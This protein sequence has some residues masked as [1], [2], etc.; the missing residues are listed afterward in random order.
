VRSLNIPA[1]L[2]RVATREDTFFQQNV[3]E[4]RQLNS[5]VAIV[6][7]VEGKELFLDPGARLCPFGL[8]EWK[9]TSARGIR[10]RAG[11]ATELAETPQPT[12][13]DATTQRVAD[14]KLQRDGTLRG[15]IA[16]VWAG[17]QA[18][19][20]R[21]DGAQTDDAGRKKAAEDELKSL[22]EA[23]A[24][25]KLDSLAS[26]DDSERP[27]KA[28]FNV[29][30]PGY[31]QITGKRVLLPSDLFLSRHLFVTETRKTPVYFEYPYRTFDRVVITLPPDVHLENLPQAQTAKADFAICSVQRT[32]TG[33]VLELRRDFALGGNVFLLTE[34]PKLKSFF[35]QVHSNDDEQVTLQTTPVTASQ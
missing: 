5:E 27:L 35:D 9:R 1:Y 22:L 28:V 11:G 2:M 30:P 24:V 19:Q 10:Q 18:L 25:V 17:Q 7:L 8:L 15:Q 14:L 4:W 13:Q 16:L 31:A 20:R 34:Y 29:E 3:P 33:N 12:Y 21:I 26:W 23:S 6:S 32:L